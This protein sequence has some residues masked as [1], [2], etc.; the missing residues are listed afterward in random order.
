MRG[1]WTGAG[2]C[3]DAHKPVNSLQ[4]RCLP[5]YS[6]KMKLESSS[7]TGYAFRI[8]EDVRR[9]VYL[10]NGMPSEIRQQLL[11]LGIQG[12][13]I[14]SLGKIRYLFPKAFDILD[15]FYKLSDFTLV[16]VEV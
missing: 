2:K 1:E 12:W 9:R 10:Q 4:R 7:G 8:M 13:L 15:S 11:E 3:R 5:L 14:E 16:S 6:G